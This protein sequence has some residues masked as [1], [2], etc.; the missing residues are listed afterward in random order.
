ML[1]ELKPL[2]AAAGTVLFRPG[3]ECPGFIRVHRG[4]IRV[5]V[6]HRMGRQ[7]LLYRIGPGELCLQTLACL[8]NGTAYTAEGVVEQELDA[9]LVPAAR[10]QAALDEPQ[11]RHEVLSG[12]AQRFGQMQQL[13]ERVAFDTVDERLVAVL[14]GRVGQDGRVQLTHE[15]IAAE[16]GIARETVTRRLSAWRKAGLVELFRG[17]VVVRQPEALRQLAMGQAGAASA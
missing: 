1:S 12:V 7:I 2:H 8:T 17:G 13:I 9:D 16:A 11:F 6:T 10:F 4:Q 15:Q 5:D 3:D 14:L